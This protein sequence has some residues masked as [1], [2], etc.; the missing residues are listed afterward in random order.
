[1]AEKILILSERQE[2][3]R[4]FRETLQTR[5]FEIETGA[6]PGEIRRAV[7][8]NAYA[9]ILAD[10][11]LLGDRVFDLAG[12][13]RH[14]RIGTSI[15]IYGETF[16]PDTVSEML[17]Q[18]VYAVVPRRRL[19]K[20]IRDTVVG[21]LENRKTF[22]EI[23]GMVDELEETN[24]RLEKEREN[25]RRKIRELRFI[26]RLSEKISYDLCWD[27]IM[28]GILDAGLL[29]V[30]DPALLALLYRMGSRWH[31]SLYLP[32]SCISRDGIETLKKKMA[33]RFLGLSGKR[34]SPVEMILHLTPARLP[35]LRLAR[36]NGHEPPEARFMA[37][38]SAVLH[39]LGLGDS[40]LGMLAVAPGGGN[41]GWKRDR[42]L[43]STLSNILA[44]SLKNA[45]E[46]HRLKEAAVTDGLTGIHNHK[47]FVDFI[48]R[49]FQRALR[50]RKPLSLVMID[51]DEFKSINDGL[52]HPAGDHVLRGL[53]GCLKAALRKSDIV[54]RYG[55][56]EFALLLP[57]TDSAR[58]RALMKRV[59]NAI[60]RHRFEW[61]SEKIR[62]DI[63]YGIATTSE[64]DG[65]RKEED[66]IRTADARLYHAKR[67]L[68]LLCPAA[69]TA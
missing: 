61:G 31:L 3:L 9:A 28:D 43:I 58:A 48:Q 39:P 64:S 65:I 2:D 59:V 63:S 66:L 26:N 52:G 56:D 23:L 27:N 46:Y 50:Y 49:E 68:R 17:Q 32:G 30:L 51:V 42:E 44:M 12:V 54:A 36:K 22:M 40:V 7:E 35:A 19:S 11:D 18:G 38:D 57:E 6:I 67:S 33:E 53:A 55:G 41:P 5:G 14:D 10:Y 21:G 60:N 62:V 20:G 45:Q 47:G 8:Q 4:L 25:L 13:L 16:E 69:R 15:I 34:I 1:M 37:G 24:Q 29:K